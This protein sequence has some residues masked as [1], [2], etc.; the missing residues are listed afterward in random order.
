[1]MTRNWSLVLAAVFLAQVARAEDDE[2]REDPW[3][4]DKERD[5][6]REEADKAD[7][8]ERTFGNSG[9]VAIS[10]ERLLGYASTSWKM[11]LKNAPDPKDTVSH[12]NLLVNANGDVATY[13]APRVAFDY[14]VTDGLSLGA[15]IGFSA[16]SGEENYREFL[17]NPRIGYAYMFGAVVGVWPRVGVTYQDQKAPIGK[18]ALLAVSVEASLVVVPAEHVA[19]TLG[20]TFDGGLVGKINPPGAEQGKTDYAQDEFGFHVGLTTFF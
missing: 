11:K 3:E 9:E 2:K 19:I 17:F 12:L 8:P 4:Y 6:K 18:V 5:A 16:A 13:S 20:P 14:F 15:S 7:A 10:A 1:M